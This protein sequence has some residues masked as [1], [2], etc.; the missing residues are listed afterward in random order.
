MKT[1]VLTS[2]HIPGEIFLHED[3]F[4]KVRCDFT[5]SDASQQQQIFLLQLADSGIT[6]TKRALSAD[7]SIQINELSVTFEMFW[8]R[9]DDKKMSSRKKSEKI[10]NKLSKVNQ[11]RAYDHIPKYF[12]I[13]PPGIRKKL[14]ETY[15]NAELWN[16]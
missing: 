14:V 6:E 16:N 10:W 11:Q 2:E 5:N 9:Y 3:D 8:N 1:F 13:I 7:P 15:L 12:N 4:G